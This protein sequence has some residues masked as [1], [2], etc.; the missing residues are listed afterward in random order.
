VKFGKNTFEQELTD[1]TVLLISAGQILDIV[2]SQYNIKRNKL[3]T[4]KS[5][6]NNFPRDL[7]MYPLEKYCMD[8]LITITGYFGN[9]HYSTVSNG[10]ARTKRMIQSD[11]CYRN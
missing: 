11:N 1:T 2:A 4:S 7:A 10:I 5:G 9:I 3:F 8:S 6:E